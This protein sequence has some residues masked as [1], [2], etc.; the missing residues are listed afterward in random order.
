MRRHTR[1]SLVTGVQTCAL[2]FYCSLLYT[3]LHRR[4]HYRLNG[5]LPLRIGRQL[6]AAAIM[7]AALLAARDP[8]LPWFAGSVGER[9]LSVTALFLAG[10]VVYFGPAWTIGSIVSLRLALFENKARR[11]VRKGCVRN[12]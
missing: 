10:V 3:I 11:R 7:A 8:L 4:G 6:I 1:C 2:P 5:K 9:A 12:F